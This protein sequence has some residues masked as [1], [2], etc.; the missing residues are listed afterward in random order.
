MSLVSLNFLIYFF[1]VNHELRSLALVEYAEYMDSPEVVMSCA[2]EMATPPADDDPKRQPMG[3]SKNRVPHPI[4][5]LIM[6]EFIDEFIY[7]L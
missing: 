6:D 5:W 3:L 4:H 7:Y 1:D 2:V